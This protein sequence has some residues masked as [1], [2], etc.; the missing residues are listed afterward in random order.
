LDTI[1]IEDGSVHSLYSNLDGIGPPL[2]LN[3]GKAMLAVLTDK[4]GHGRIWMISYPQGQTNPVTHDLENYDA[5]LEVTRDAKTIA[6]VS[7]TETSNVYVAQA[8]GLF[9]LEANH[10]W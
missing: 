1:S 7:V 3:E 4:A 5:S 2:W 6:A 10:V 8:P 9:P